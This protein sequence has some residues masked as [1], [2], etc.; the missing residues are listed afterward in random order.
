M[1][2]LA[3]LVCL[4][5]HVVENDSFGRVDGLNL[6]RLHHVLLL[7]WCDGIHWVLL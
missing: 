2:L 4:I 5:E 6:K 3:S 7:E 1:Y